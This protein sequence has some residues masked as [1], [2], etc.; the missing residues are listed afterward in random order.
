[1]ILETRNKEGVVHREKFTDEFRF[2]TQ[3]NK[4]VVGWTAREGADIRQVYIKDG[5]SAKVLNDTGEV[6]FSV[7]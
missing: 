2:F 1:M 5:T 4:L 7:F 6:V 3:T